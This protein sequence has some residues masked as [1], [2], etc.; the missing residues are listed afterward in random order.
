MSAA[1][2][3]DA[4]KL[5]ERI[6]IMLDQGAFTSTY[7]YAVLLALMDIC[8]ERTSKSGLAP[9][10]ITTRQ[11]A[12][13]VIEIYWPHTTPFQRHAR[14]VLRQNTG[15]GESQAE[16]VRVIERF[17]GEDLATLTAAVRADPA[18]YRR[19]VNAVELKLIEMPLPK[20]QRIGRTI[21]PYLYHISWDDSVNLADV[22]A[23]QAGRPSDFDNRIHLQP[24]VGGS[25]VRLNNL[26]RP[27]IHRQWTVKVAGINQL[28]ESDLE[29][30]L[31]GAT[32][33]PLEKLRG[34][35]LEFQNARCFYCEER[36]G[37]SASTRPE[38]DH[39]IAWARYPDD[40]LANL[41]VAHQKCNNQKRDFLAATGHVVKWLQRMDVES[42]SGRDL[43]NLA[44]DVQWELRD[45]ETVGVGAAIY[46]RLGDDVELWEAGERFAAVRAVELGKAFDGC[47]LP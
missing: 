1:T 45:H 33:A 23:Y 32:R 28:L 40:G 2:D 39:F 37:S 7:K 46:L 13:K 12:A 11:L 21:R 42:G 10:M 17:R 26:L 35:L 30:F 20:L 34:P 18:G 29:Q 25:L 38:V 47:V 4:I 44:R 43:G 9:E 14:G 22:R 6:M 24:G 41:V 16:I 15:R 27:L 19:V 3:N 31:F 36:I 8:M 5:A